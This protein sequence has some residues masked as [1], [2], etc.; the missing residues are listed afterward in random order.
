MARIMSCFLLATVTLALAQATVPSSSRLAWPP[1]LVLWWGQELV[2]EQ[3]WQVL[4]QL[5]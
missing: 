4:A 3:S 1:A 2:L 5:L